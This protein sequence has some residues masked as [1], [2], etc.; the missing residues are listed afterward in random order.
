MIPQYNNNLSASFYLW[1]DHEICSI[2][3]A[4]QNFSGLLYPTTDPN[5]AGYNK[6]GSPF[7]QWVCDSSIEN[8]NIPSG[9]Y[10]GN[11]FIPRGTSGLHIDYG[12]MLG[13]NGGRVISS[14]IPSG[15]TGLSASYCIKDFNIYYTNIDEAYLLFD[16]APTLPDQS[17]LGFQPTGAL[18]YKDQPYP[19]IYFKFEDSQD[20]GFAFGGLDTTKQEVRCVILS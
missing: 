20:D 5:F 12:N 18:F 16:L 10:N 13:E 14:G 7:R 3:Q 6:F 8:A 17:Q 9:V 4:Y 11:T 19:S 2:G 1:L 15:T